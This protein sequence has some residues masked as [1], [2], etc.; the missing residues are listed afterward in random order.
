MVFWL[1]ANDKRIVGFTAR[2]TLVQ[3][4]R[5]NGVSPHGE[6]ADRSDVGNVSKKVEHDLADERRSPMIET[7]FSEVNVVR[8]LFSTGEGE[9]T[10][11][12]SLV[13]DGVNELRAWVGHVTIV[14]SIPAGESH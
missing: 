11:K 7:Q 2:D 1:F 10:V 6:P 4:C 9:I 13:C 12:N 5:R 8:R 14:A 3:D